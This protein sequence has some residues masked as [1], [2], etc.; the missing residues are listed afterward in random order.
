M[1]DFKSI[2]VSTNHK[3]KC[4]LPH[5]KQFQ[6]NRVDTLPLTFKDDQLFNPRPDGPL[7]F[8]PLFLRGRVFEHPRLSQHRRTKLKSLFESSIKLF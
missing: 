6:T 2:F 4:S 8:P 7:D 3:I 5:E 1:R